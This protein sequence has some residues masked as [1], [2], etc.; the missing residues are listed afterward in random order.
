MLCW[1]RVWRGSRW[2]G[3]V[4]PHR[5]ILWSFFLSR[6]PWIHGAPNVWTCG[7]NKIMESWLLFTHDTSKEGCCFVAASFGLLGCW[8][9]YFSAP[10]LVHACSAFFFSVLCSFYYVN[11]HVHICICY[12]LVG[13]RCTSEG[14]KCHGKDRAQLRNTAGNKRLQLQIDSVVSRYFHNRI[15]SISKQCQAVVESKIRVGT[16]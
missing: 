4:F 5:R 9:L 7:R 14:C 1:P 8:S 10:V 2:I 3:L 12:V 13:R 6:E 11:I 15:T 16:V